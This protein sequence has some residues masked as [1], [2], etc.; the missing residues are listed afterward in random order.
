MAAVLPPL[1]VTLPLAAICPVVQSVALP[2]RE[3]KQA[4]AAFRQ[5]HR[6]ALAVLHK[7]MQHPGI[8]GFRISREDAH[9]I[10]DFA[11]TALLLAG[12]SDESEPPERLV[13]K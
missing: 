8:S 11:G 5:E 12:W 7:K 2:P 13:G 9:W 1:P 10:L 3:R 6:E 4:N